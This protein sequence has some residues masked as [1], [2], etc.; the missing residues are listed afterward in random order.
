M[1]RTLAQPGPERANRLIFIGAVALALLAAVAAAIAFGYLNPGDDASE[2]PL[3]KLPKISL[4]FTLVHTEPDPVAERAGVHFA[5][6][7]REGV[8]SDARPAGHP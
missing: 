1:A 3:A 8:P 5:R 7:R 2:G 6:E 4:P